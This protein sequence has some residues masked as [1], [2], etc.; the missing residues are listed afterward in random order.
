MEQEKEKGEA[1][2]INV[3]CEM[4]NGLYARTRGQR[5]EWEGEHIH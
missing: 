4:R 5:G 3:K 1:R 2:M